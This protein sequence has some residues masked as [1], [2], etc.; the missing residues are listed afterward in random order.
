MSES[1]IIITKAYWPSS[2][3]LIDLKSPMMN[4]DGLEIKDISIDATYSDNNINFKK[5]SGK[6]INGKIEISG[7]VILKDQFPFNI[8][9]KFNNVSLNTLFNQIQIN[10]WDRLN[11]KLS[12][13]DFQIKGF[14]KNKESLINFAEGK[15]KISG[16]GYLITTDEE[17]FGTALLS[18]LV[19]KLPSLTSISK[20]LNFIISTYG[21]VP[22]AITGTLDIK[23]GKITSNDIEI[24][25]DIGK[26]S[27]IASLDLKKNII[28]GKIFF[29]ENDKIFLETSLKGNINNPQILID[30]KV[31]QENEEPKD[32]KKILKEGINSL[33]DNILQIK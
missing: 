12:S 3:F 28:D 16:S 2:P 8:Q 26:S 4:L 13:N 19:E 1:S 20:S 29:Y 7:N 10:F 5:I 32:L 15:A 9:G 14:A 22:S 21:N 24:K 18:L 6:L 33:I 11:V 17:R 25:N 31:L 23:N 27:I 30:D